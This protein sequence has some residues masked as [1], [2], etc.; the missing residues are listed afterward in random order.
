MK[1]LEDKDLQDYLNGSDRVTATYQSL[2]LDKALQD[3]KP[4]AAID[5][6]IF[7]AA[8]E[9][10]AGKSMQKKGIPRQVYSIAASVCV[11]VLAVS[12]F[13][14]NEDELTGADL[15]AL[16]IPV[17]DAP[18]LQ[19]LEIISADNVSV[20]DQ[21][22]INA[23]TFSE[24]LEP[25]ANRIA[26][27]NQQLE[28][29]ALSAAAEIS[30]QSA[31]RGAQRIAEPSAQQ[32]VLENGETAV[33][34]FNVDYRQNIGTWLLEIQRLSDIGNE[35]ELAEERRLF[36]ERYPDMDIDSVLTENQL[37]N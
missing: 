27:Q 18:M 13:L 30:L 33:Q 36:A 6:A 26:T 29:E 25:T 15:E 22:R 23:S 4:S 35:D 1:E 21:N 32:E 10:V 12:L 24:Q 20:E 7:Q 5:D 16:S 31:E 19:R 14:N 17:S 11:A 37:S 9:S 2:Q 8:R 3:Q 34:V 28:A